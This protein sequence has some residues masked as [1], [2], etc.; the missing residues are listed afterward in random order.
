MLETHAI[1]ALG[2]AVAAKDLSH[3]MQA[4]GMQRKD[5]NYCLSNH[6]FHGSTHCTTWV[7]WPER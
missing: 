4:A 3:G 2:A 5:L 7:C 6:L 1:C